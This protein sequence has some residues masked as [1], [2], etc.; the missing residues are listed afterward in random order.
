M[1]RARRLASFLLGAAAVAAGAAVARRALYRADLARLRGRVVLIV[2]GSRGLGF[3][4][5]RE[6]AEGGA[7]VTIAGRDAKTLHRAQDALE[8][9]GLE[10]D[11]V[12]CDVRHRDDAEAL[13]AHVVQ[14]SGPID[15]LLNVAGVIQ[16]GSVWDQGLDDFDESIETH[17]YGPLYTMRAV[18]PAMRA[19]GEGRIANVSSVGALVGVPHLAPYCAGKFGLVGLSQAYSAEVAHDGVTVTTICPG[20][21]RTGSPDNAYFKGRTKAEYGWF[22]LS[23]ANPF[24]SVS[25]ARAVRTIVTAVVRRK[26]FVAIGTLARVAQIGNAIAPSTTTRMLALVARLLPP[27]LEDPSVKRLGRDSHSALAPSLLTALDQ[28]AKRKNNEE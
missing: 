27:P 1:N 26:P 14:H 13:V 23:A 28:I 19:R 8:A 25:T 15:V 22:A 3:A 17:L 2:G 6:L 10:V 21:M 12:P 20:L 11:A 5:A 18:L 7:S 4:L 16:V 24:I 9:A